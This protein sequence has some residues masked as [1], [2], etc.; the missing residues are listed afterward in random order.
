MH[1]K[2]ITCICSAYKFPHRLTGGKCDG[3]SWV[4]SYLQLIGEECKDCACSNGVSCEV[5]TG[6]E[7]IT[8]AQCI[9]EELHTSS[10]YDSYG[11]LPLSTEA[12]I[13]E[14]YKREREEQEEV[15]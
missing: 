7:A 2:Q 10:I 5:A 15:Y 6:T 11:K 8:E 3:Q 14:L 12:Y 9:I 13:E 1:S 4:V